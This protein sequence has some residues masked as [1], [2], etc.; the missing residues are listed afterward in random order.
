MAVQQTLAGMVQPKRPTIRACILSV[1]Q[2]EPG[3][4]WKP[5]DLI[6]IVERMRG[7]L[8]S[9][10]SITAKTRDLRKAA[11]GGHD[12]RSERVEGARVYRYWLEP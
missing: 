3:R 7:E 10:S 5:Y 8:C 11:Y 12:I 6:A 9:E 4:K 2:R 1:L